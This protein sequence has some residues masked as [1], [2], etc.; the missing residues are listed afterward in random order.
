MNHW[1]SVTVL[2]DCISFHELE[3]AH[4]VF[5]LGV[6]LVKSQVVISAGLEEMLFGDNWEFELDDVFKSVIL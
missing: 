5:K 4:G 6:D 3:M 2:K 1:A